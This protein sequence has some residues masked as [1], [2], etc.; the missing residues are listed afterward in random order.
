MALRLEVIEYFD[1]SNRSLVMR[2]PAQGS[3]EIKYGA[4]LIVHQNQEAVFFRDG[5]AMD[6]FGPGRH[7]LTT[8]NIP[9]LTRLLTAP[10]EKSPFR[11]LVYFVGKQTF[12]DQKWG[13]RQPIVFRDEE[14]GMV[15][16]RSFGKYSFRVADSSVLINTLVGTKGMYTTSDV[17]AYLRDMIVARMTDLLGTVGIRLLDLPSRFDELASA[18]RAKVADEFAK[19]G[20][21]LVDFYIN[22]ITP[23]EEVQQ[24]IDA[25]MSMG[26][27]GDLRSYTMFQAANSMR[28]L[29]EQ[30]GEG[31]GGAMGM[32][33]SAGL[34]MM[35][36][37]FLQKAMETPSAPARTPAS[38]PSPATQLAA[39]Q[40]PPHDPLEL[41]RKVAKGSGWNVKE[42]DRAWTL[43][44]PVGPLRRQLVHVR[45]DRAD[46]AGNQL[47]SLSSICG[48]AREETAMA[49]LKHNTKMVHSSFA[50]EATEAGEM[51]VVEANQL[52]DTADPLQISR[53]ISAIAWQADQA[54]HQLLGTD[55]F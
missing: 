48:P 11:A 3:A 43:E 41:V 24:A 35:L 44:V 37:T 33:M 17:A 29:A 10:W 26:A 32:G 31:G 38:S 18:T 36:P 2:V 14:F 34:G 5:Q 45:F 6:V 4:Q 16:L 52:A 39:L 50:I 23:P 25:R 47:I 40:A 19:Y 21:E 53:A 20:L 12:I 42:S 22:A 54:E 8:A 7:T 13:T 55:Q 30:S 49:L 1:P 9:L 28:K 51:V 46:E 27:I 15:R